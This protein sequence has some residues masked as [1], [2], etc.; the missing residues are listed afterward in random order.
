MSIGETMPSMKAC[1]RAIAGARMF[2]TSRSVTSSGLSPSLPDSIQSLLPPAIARRTPAFS[3]ESRAN[4]GQIVH[5][6]LGSYSPSKKKEDIRCFQTEL[7][8]YARSFGLC[9]LRR[10][11]L[12]I[13][14]A[15][16]RNDVRR[17]GV[18]ARLPDA[19]AAADA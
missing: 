4:A 7:L 14:A 13:D 2:R 6:L 16:V 1:L 11:L 10:Q 3:S 5:A 19:L 8:S 15:I 17:Q 9:D 18:S 12:Q